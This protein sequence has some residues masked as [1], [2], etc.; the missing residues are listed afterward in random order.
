MVNFKPGEYMWKM[1]SQSVTQ[2][3]RRRKS[4][5]SGVEPLTF[6]FFTITH[7]VHFY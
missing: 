3:A 1:I 7:T 5:C 6:W 2:A 4:E